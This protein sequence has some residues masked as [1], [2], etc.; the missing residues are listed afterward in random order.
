MTIIGWIE[1]FENDS[2]VGY[3]SP[4]YDLKEWIESN[5]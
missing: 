4:Y 3:Y 2:M 5:A 1:I